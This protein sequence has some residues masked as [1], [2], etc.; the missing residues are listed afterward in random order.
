MALAWPAPG[1]ARR[2]HARVEATRWPFV[3]MW[4]YLVAQAF[5]IPLVAIGP[6]PIWP[7]LADLA[8]GFLL[9][10]WLMSPKSAERSATRS[11]APLVVFGLLAFCAASYVL[12]T[13][14][15]EN[16]DVLEFGSKRG[17]Q[18]G[19][20]QLV[21]LI[22]FATLFWL[23][24]QIPLTPF[25]LHVLLRSARWVL[26]IV[27][28]LIIAT[29]LGLIAQ[30]AVVGHLPAGAVAVGPWQVLLTSIHDQGLGAV[31]YNHAYVAAQ[32]TALLALCLHL[33]PRDAIWSQIGLISLST[34]A[35]TVTGSRAG[36]LAHL[37]F[38]FMYLAWRSWPTLIVLGV[39]GIALTVAPGAFSPELPQTNTSQTLT[40][41]QQ[42]TLPILERQRTV[43]SLGDG[44][45]L[46]G[47][48]SIWQ[49]K[50]SALNDSPLHWVT[51]WGFGTSSDHGYGITAHM[52]PLQIVVEMGLIGF[53]VF[54]VVFAALLMALWK[55]ESAPKVVFLLAI[56]L[57]VSS[58]SQEN[59]YPIA[60]MG[61]FLGLFL[62][63]VAIALRQTLGDAGRA[64]RL[65]GGL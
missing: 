64:N 44:E 56:A 28:G 34:A 9:L 6:W 15:L 62:V 54:S 14:V 50:V 60:A 49:E 22:Q 43:F 46:S 5:T 16:L 1:V 48:D 20:F 11:R 55:A 42:E 13:V 38:L 17:F 24:S 12:F 25:R 58:L 65:R 59:F 21:R 57:Q 35:V 37:L 63:I 33:A 7:T 52:L 32:A 4:A 29:Y 51:G 26:V 30:S 8:F 23:V 53:A 18:T 47:R 36:L 40:S 19:A 39:L 61:H 45:S 31:G 10:A 41:E 3:G 27:S 2:A